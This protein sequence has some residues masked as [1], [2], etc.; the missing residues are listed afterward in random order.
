MKPIDYVRLSRQPPCPHCLIGYMDESLN[1]R[2]T[3]GKAN[4][5]F[6]GL[7]CTYQDWEVCPLNKDRLE[8]FTPK[9][10]GECTPYKDFYQILS[11]KGIIG[12]IKRVE[13]HYISSDKDEAMIFLEDGRIISSSRRKK[14]E[15]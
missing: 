3:C 14:N 11:E 7:P 15:R 6:Q 13:I 10:K 2:V 8:I 9:G 5:T 4:I 1:T 12:T